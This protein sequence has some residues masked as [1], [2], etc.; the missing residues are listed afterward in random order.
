MIMRTLYSVVKWVILVLLAYVFFVEVILRIIHRFYQFPIPGYV[1]RLLDNPIRR[2]L[3]PPEKI[4]AWMGVRPGMTLLEIGPGPGTFTFAA[5][6]A[7]GE[8]GRVHAVDIQAMVIRTLKNKINQHGTGTIIP[9]QASAYEL[10][11]AEACFDRIYMIT[12][13]GEI[14]N[15]H[16]A[17]AEIGRVLKEDGSLAIGEFLPDPDFPLKRTVIQWCEESGFHLRAEH[18]NLI[19]Y[20]LLFSRA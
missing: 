3:Q 5:A 19:H 14:P 7:V 6:E 15:K 16:R 18:G 9:E 1:A 8:E 20:L 17:L 4:V 13:L 2:S 11:F 12:V 10:P